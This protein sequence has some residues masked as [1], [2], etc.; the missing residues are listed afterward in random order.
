MKLITLF[1]SVLLVA[2]AA[3]GGGAAVEEAHGDDAHDVEPAA[4]ASLEVA[5]KDALFLVQMTNFAFSPSTLDVKTGDVIEIAIQ[6]VTTE[7]HDF[8]IERIDADLHISYLGGAGTHEHGG[9]AMAADLHFVLTEP[10]SGVVHIKVHEPG[11]YIFYC[12]IPGHREL[13]MEGT[14]IVTSGEH[15]G[16]DD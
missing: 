10:G 9:T 6:N 4:A 5:P 2:A 16:H 1:M 3:C 13:G 7:P 12:S 15:D 14:L 11:E 8:T